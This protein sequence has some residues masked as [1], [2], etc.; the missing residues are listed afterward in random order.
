MKLMQRFYRLA[1]AAALL[2][3]L[4]GCGYNRLQ[5]EDEQVKANHARVLSVSKKRYDLVPNLVKTV[6][7]FAVQ[8]KD[9]FLGVAS[10]R[11]K[12]GQVT[13]PENAT[14]EQM[15]QFTDAQKEMGGALS[16]LLVVAENYPQ[17]KS[18][19]NFLRLQKTLEDLE[20][21]LAAARNQY[22]KSVQA[23]NVTVRSFP[24]NLT[25]MLFGYEKKAQLQVEDEA[26]IKQ[27]PT[28]DFGVPKAEPKA[29]AK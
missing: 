9:V 4:S 18:D 25:A 7:G 17:L 16:K 2:S 27:A 19:A 20:T 3:L 28:V 29:A 24:T 6:Q 21:Q 5:T 10:A 13:L 11:A 12:V 1:L 14:P 22:I 15:K 26:A 8:E 23:Y